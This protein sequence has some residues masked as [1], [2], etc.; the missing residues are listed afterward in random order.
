MSTDLEVPSFVG[1]CQSALVHFE[2]QSTTSPLDLR[3]APARRA[4]ES[5]LGSQDER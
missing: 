5:I 1:V 3:K 2:R 4:G